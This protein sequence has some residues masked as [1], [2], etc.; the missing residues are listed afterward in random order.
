MD[1]TSRV[2]GRTGRS[3][4]PADLWMSWKRQSEGSRAR[5]PSLQSTPV[6][7][8]AARQTPASAQ[9]LLPQSSPNSCEAGSR[10]ALCPEPREPWGGLA[11]QPILPSPELKPLLSLLQFTQSALDCMSVE[12]GRLR[13]FLQV[14]WHPVPL[15]P[16]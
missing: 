10:E 6:L 5:L 4:Y 11:Q 13:S 7:G 3:C 1:F 9:A 14:S 12:V 16:L 8:A 2:A 15:V